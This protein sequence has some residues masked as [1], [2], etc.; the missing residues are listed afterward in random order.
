MRY[1]VAILVAVVL[2]VG[3]FN[4][5][6]WKSLHTA[7][8]F[9]PT[10]MAASGLKAVP[11][12][13]AS[14]GQGQDRSQAEGQSQS[15]AQSPAPSNADS[16]VDSSDIP[17]V[18]DGGDI[19]RVT[20]PHGN[21]KGPQFEVA[22]Q[23]PPGFDPVD[24]GTAYL[25]LDT[26]GEHVSFVTLDL[27]RTD[28]N[29]SPQHNQ[30]TVQLTVADAYNGN[31]VR[32]PQAAISPVTA[33]SSRLSI[34][35]GGGSPW[36]RVR[37]TDPNGTRFRIDRIVINEAVPFTFSPWRFAALLFIALAVASLL[38]GSWMW[39]V[40]WNAPFVRRRGRGRGR[41]RGR[42]GDGR[43]HDGRDGERDHARVSESAS[44]GVR[45]ASASVGV[46]SAGE[47]S[48]GE[49][50]REP[51]GARA[52]DGRPQPADITPAIRVGSWLVLAAIVAAQILLMLLAFKIAAPR[53]LLQA[54]NGQPN[55]ATIYQDQVR[56]ILAGHAWLDRPVP[57]ALL[58]M[59]NPYDYSLREAVTAGS[60]TPVIP[61]YAYKDGHYWQ[62][63]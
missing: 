2:E 63:H 28:T 4:T 15:R 13:G 61:D 20:L 30:L 52:R 23:T 58:N 60:S 26:R 16:D 18:I 42:D 37:V 11:A 6:H 54:L 49:R 38:P 55:V 40:A 24:K 17:G 22:D 19:T 10:V 7:P 12:E 39:R 44:V 47:R 41:E 25:L 36:M 53:Q 3:V 62:C 21:A 43:D 32:F 31:G 48:A 9:E 59:A 51:V 34:V 14:G 50:N 56:A 35:T 45:S 1:V 29:P 46:R 33:Q 5:P 27:V 8:A 57:D